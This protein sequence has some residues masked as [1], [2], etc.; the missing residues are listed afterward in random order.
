MLARDI[1]LN[2]K[3]VELDKE[4]LSIIVNRIIKDINETLTIRNLVEANIENNKAILK[5]L[6]KGLLLMD[7]NQKYLSKFL[8]DGKLTKKDLL[9][10]YSGEEIKDKFKLIESQINIL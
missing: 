10:F 1:A 7:F 4:L 9:D 5:Q 6:E 8:S 2:A 3:E